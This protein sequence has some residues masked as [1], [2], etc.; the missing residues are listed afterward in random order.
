MK[1]DQLQEEVQLL[2]SELVRKDAIIKSLLATIEST[3][4]TTDDGFVTSSTPLQDL[5]QISKEACDAVTPMLK[6]F[7]AKI[8][9]QR[10][11]GSSKLKSDATYFTIADGI[12]QH[13]FINHL[14]AGNKFAQIVGEEDESVINILQKPFTVDDLTVP[15][16]FNAIIASTLKEIDALGKRIDPNLYQS[17]TVFVDPIDGTREFA[18]AQGQY[19]TI[20]IGYNDAVGHPAAGIMYRPLTSPVTWAAGAASEDVVMGDL[21]MADP[22]VPNGMLITDG[23]VSPFIVDL[24][25]EMGYE[26]VS[27][28]ASGNRA[29]M[30][31]EGK[32]GAYIRDTGGFA[33][34]DT[35]APTAVLEAYGGT[36]SKLP[37]FLDDE[38]LVGYT[39]LK[40][41]KNLDF[42]PG[43]SQLTLS[44]IRDKSA[45]VKGSE[46]SVSDVNS[47]KEYSCMQGLVAVDKRAMKDLP[48]IREAMK[49]VQEEHA[50][51]YT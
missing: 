21:D 29:M 11:G 45:F 25:D 30:L 18:T 48:K 7:Y 49:V 44:N 47:V 10:H 12:V 16:E 8:S 5:C 28:V 51:T 19:V 37:P 38:S 24:I 43:Q 14:F 26:R 33:K 6:A 34:W 50:P 13:M 27:S 46:I 35:S 15:D 39:H 1:L 20:L 23:K 36:M 4:V 42:V 9:D 32:G 22:P 2:R 41:Q 3:A 17:M 40:S 31:L